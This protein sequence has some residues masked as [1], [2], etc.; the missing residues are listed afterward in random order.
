MNYKTHT[1]SNGIRLIHKFSDSAIAHC[2]IVV[3]TGSRDESEN[4]HGLAHLIE[5]TIFKGTAKRKSF[6]II[7]RI[8]DVGGEIN[9]YTS[10]EETFIFSS[11][12]SEYFGRTV[13]LLSD[14]MFNSI[15]PEKEIKKEI[16]V[17][18]D[19]INSY[20]DSPSELIFDEF[21]EMIFKN[22]SIGRQILGEPNILKKFGKPEIQNFINKNYNTDEIVFCSI[23]NISFEKVKK[24]FEK[25]FSEVPQNLR[26]KSRIAFQNYSPEIRSENKDTYQTHSIIGNIAYSM[27][28]KNRIPM[29]LLNNILGGQN[30]NSRLNIALREKTGYSYNVESSYVPNTDTGV[31]YVYF[32]SDLSNL[33][34]CNDLV[35]KEFSKLRTKKLGVLQ[36]SKAKRQLMGQIAIS[37][38]NNSNLLLSIGKNFLH[39]NKIEGLKEINRKIE[40]ITAIN[41]LE[42]SN[43]ILDHKKLSYLNYK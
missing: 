21:E 19:E 16:E 28:D 1:L 41:L 20:K 27:K 13:E 4:E 11:F 25:Y 29:V 6:Q 5:H 42:I 33:Q 15:F 14:I 37:Y 39:F 23:G 7:G 12:L 26:K 38:E 2:G 22:H 34:K 32:S 40:N 8:E 3:N 17:I 31:F 24:Y 35:L 10:K 30:L 36:L 9:A 43:E 18:I